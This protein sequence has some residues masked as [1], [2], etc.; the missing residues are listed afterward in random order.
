MIKGEEARRVSNHMISSGMAADGRC[1]RFHLALPLTH[2]YEVLRRVKPKVLEEGQV[3]PREEKEG[4]GG[5]IRSGGGGG[6]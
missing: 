1:P 3:P 4:G 5:G 6:G 2:L